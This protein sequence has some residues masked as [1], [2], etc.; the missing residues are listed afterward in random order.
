M[1][2]AKQPS[3][4]FYFG[5]WKKDPAVSVCSYAAR[6]LWLEML[7]LMFDSVERG[8]L[9]T[10]AG[11]PMTPAQLCRATGGDDVKQVQS[12]L[13]ELKENGVYSIDDQGRIYNRRMVRD[14][15]VSKVR[16]EAANR[17]WDGKFAP[18]LH[19]SDG[20]VCNANTD[21][22]PDA[23]GVQNHRAS[24]S[25]SSSASASASSAASAAAVS[26]VAVVWKT[27]AETVRRFFDAA[28]DEIIARI[29]AAARKE[30]A[31]ITDWQ[32]ANAVLDA[33]KQAQGRQRSPALFEITVPQVVRT[34]RAVMERENAQMQGASA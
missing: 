31:D 11:K 3:L 4:Q 21:A 24:S 7:G 23:N 10:D 26:Q 1:S 13:D 5:D 6:G 18:G 33:A 9:L 15:A 19:P 8:Y 16:T 14:T 22:K 28:D 27:T 17:R 34:Y 20:E 29:A 12:L 30:Y 25:S 2:V 32:C